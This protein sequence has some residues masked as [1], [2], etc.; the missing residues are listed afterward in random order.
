VDARGTAG[1]EIAASFLT[2]QG[3]EILAR[4]TRVAGVEVD[5]VARRDTLLVV[6]EVKTRGSRRQTAADAVR[7]PQ[8]LRLRRAATALLSRAPWAESLRID[9]IGIDWREGELRAQHWRGVG[10]QR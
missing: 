5:L 7:I 4:N 3:Y 2:L 8:Q 1:E 10:A 9:A 6:V